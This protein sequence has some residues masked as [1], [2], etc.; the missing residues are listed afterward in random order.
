MADKVRP[1]IK[2]FMVHMSKEEN[3][4]FPAIKFM[5]D[6]KRKGEKQAG[7]GGDIARGICKME[8][9]HDETRA[10]LKRFREITDDYKLPA[11]AF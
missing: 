1:M 4:L 6:L 5:L 2:D 8:E 11:D 3:V 9:E 10:F 7:P